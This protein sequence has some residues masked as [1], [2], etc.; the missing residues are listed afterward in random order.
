MKELPLAA[1]A[2]GGPEAIVRLFAE[3][4]TP[5]TKALM[6]SHITSQFGIRMPVVELVGLAR[7][8]GA[9]SLIDGAQAVGQ[10][11]VDVRAL[12]CDAYV[13]SPHKWLLAPKGTGVLYIR[14][15]VQDR[16]WTTLAS[17]Q[18]ENREE[19]AFRFMQYGTGSV[20]QVEGLLAAL[21]FVEAIGIDRIE[22]WDAMLTKR[23]REGLARMPRARLSSPRDPRLA[24]AHHHV[25]RRG[26]HRPRPPGRALGAK[27]PRARPGGR[28]GR[29]A[30]R[31][32]LCRA[33]RYRRRPRDR[34]DSRGRL[35]VSVR[36]S[37]ALLALGAVVLSA[38][39]ACARSRS[40]QPP[41]QSGSRAA[42]SGPA[43]SPPGPAGYREASRVRA[44]VCFS[45]T[46]T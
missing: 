8:R 14:R 2:A 24:A 22:R 45:A 20:A 36:G 26:R 43:S 44:A 41:H 23:L 4:M 29:E 12:G 31:S 5:R 35:R 37:L 6:V 40:W 34:R 18:F 25:P 30:V 7:E 42:W 11:R 19:G 39:T 28:Q 16:F 27:D 21:A 17:Y 15:A 33:G 38:E 32:P 9:L 13:A 3:A 46:K 10:I 1:A